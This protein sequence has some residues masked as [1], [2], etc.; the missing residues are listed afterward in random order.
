M[1]QASVKVTG[2]RTFTPFAQAMENTIQTAHTQKTK[3]LLILYLQTIRTF[4]G[5]IFMLIEK[6]VNHENLHNHIVFIANAI[7]SIFF[8][9][10]KMI[11]YTQ[12]ST[13]G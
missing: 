9:K 4:Q 12:G 1:D 13:A 2:E 3:L 8:D 7:L 5:I 11:M 6:F 10:S